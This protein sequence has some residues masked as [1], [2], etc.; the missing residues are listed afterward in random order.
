MAACKQLA[1]FFIFVVVQCGAIEYYIIPTDNVNVSCPLNQTCL[2]IN[3]YTNPSNNYLELNNSVFNFLPG[4]H[5]MER[6]MEFNNVENITL[7]AMENDNA[8]L[9]LQLQPSYDN[10]I[11][12]CC[13]NLLQC[14]CST[15]GMKGVTNVTIN[16]LDIGTAV[17]ISGIIIENS[18]DIEIKSL[19]ISNV[20]IG[21]LMYNVN[22]AMVQNSSFQD[23][24]Y[25]GL[26]ITD[27][28]WI[29]LFDISIHNNV[30]GLTMRSAR[31]SSL[32]NINV[33]LSRSIGF[34]LQ[35]CV[36]T[37]MIYI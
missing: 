4:K 34:T 25:T 20:V 35:D 14:C 19:Y 10:D 32:E 17:K 29:V 11:S 18:T 23:C 28:N 8:Q 24:L 3:E 31:Y 2:T 12:R 21:V 36:D 5:V 15:I 37:T 26:N 13:E 22:D 7:Q 33:T 1:L 16:G 9:Q 30:V 27:A 6:P